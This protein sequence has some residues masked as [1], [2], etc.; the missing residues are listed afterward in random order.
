VAGRT[1]AVRSWQSIYGLFRR[2]QRDGTWAR[3]LARLQQLDDAAGLICWDVS[4]DST[5]VRAHQH[6]AGACRDPDGQVESPGE[7]PA[8]HALGGLA[9]GG[10][11]SCIWPASRDA[12]RCR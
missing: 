9:V 2:W 1:R 8:D 11:P 6:A 5:I 4:V 10:P 3:I 12:S 7:E